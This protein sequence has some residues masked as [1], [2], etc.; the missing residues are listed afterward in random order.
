MCTHQLKYQLSYR[1]WHNHCCGFAS[2]NQPEKSMNFL[3]IILLTALISFLSIHVYGQ[4][5]AVVQ[6]RTP[7]QE[8][9]RQTEK[10]QN[11]LQ[12]TPEQT[13]LVNEINLKYARERKFSNTRSDALRRIKEKDEDLQRVLNQDQFRQLQNKRYDRS[14]FQPS[15][16]GLNYQSDFNAGQ[17]RRSTYQPTRANNT[18]SGERK[19]VTSEMHRDYNRINPEINTRSYDSQR[20]V[21]HNS[22]RTTQSSGS[23]ESPS[24]LRSGSSVN[25]TP[26]AASSSENSSSRSNYSAPRSS[27]NSSSSSGS[28]GSNR[29]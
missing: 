25:N 10:L 16:N 13:Q 24:V 28:S 15:V 4:E 11:E 1:F 19:T 6:E 20:S 22:T 7:E 9:A 3:R 29:R 14:S 18:E 5:N 8:A 2:I 23:Y 27:G 21:Q 12:L 26:R 17:N